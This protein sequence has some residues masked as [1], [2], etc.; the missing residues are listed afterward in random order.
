M[1]DRNGGGAGVSVAEGLRRVD[2]AEALHA[3]LSALAADA[4]RRR[5]WTRTQVRFYL[6]PTWHRN[7]EGY[8]EGEHL[9]A[10]AHLP[11]APQE[12]QALAVPQALALC[13]EHLGSG[14]DERAATDADL[15][16][17]TAGL[18]ELLAGPEPEG[19]APVAHMLRAL[20][21]EMRAADAKQP[22]RFRISQ[23]R[24]VRGDGGRFVY[25][26]IW[27]SE[28]DPYAPGE[29]RLG[30][31]W[32]PARVGEPAPDDA[33]RY[34]IIVEEWLGPAI[35]PTIFRVDPTFLLRV[36]Y[37]RLQA[38]DSMSPDVSVWADRL[39]HPPQRDVA[40]ANLAGA[41]VSDLNARQRDAIGIAMAANRS[42]VWGPPGTGK[43]TTIGALARTQ[44]GLGRRVLILSPY[45]VAVDEAVLSVARGT[46]A[47]PRIL[48]LGRAGTEVR[49][50]GFDLESQLE[51]AAARTGLLDTARGL[52]AAI[53]ARQ[54]GDRVSPPATVRGC[55]DELGGLVVRRGTP[56][57]DPQ[58][59]A[60]VSAVAQ[61]RNAFR[62]PEGALLRGA[63]V[64]ACTMAL[65]FL[66]DE[67]F[68]S[69]F[70]QLI[71]DEA[72]VVRS[73]EAVLAATCAAAPVAFFGDPKQLP[74]IVLTQESAGSRWLG[75]SPFALAGVA[76]PA[77]AAGACVLLDEQHRMAPPIRDI[78]S[79]LFYD[80]KLRDAPNAP[81]AGRVVLV[82]TA[83][84]GARATPKFIRLSQSKENLLHRA[85][86]AE[87][88]R[89][90]GRKNPEA[91]ALVVSP[92]VAQKRAYRRERTT[93]EALR[94]APRFETIHSS[95]GT[96]QDIVVLDLVLAGNGVG[97]R[98]RML[99]ERRN[100]HLPNLLN[101][102]ISRAKHTLVIVGD[103][104]LVQREYADGKLAALV[105]RVR[106]V[107]S[108]VEVERRL[109]GLRTALQ[110]AL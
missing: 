31:R 89:A 104:D 82:N 10:P 3:M 72:S 48:R 70:G 41:P 90:I 59:R 20:R 22:K 103:L 71:V 14:A 49:Q 73:P 18:R 52:L 76:Q 9:C 80:G 98:S 78:V 102:A 61:I 81:R 43:T 67:V 69:P 44:L 99:D 36:V 45:N 40:A 23:G 107:G 60:I 96:E 35:D 19:N 12:L 101:V 63:D 66:K 32:I 7:A 13:T 62:G 2:S 50:A 27:S 105:D 92:F 24:C 34:E 75:R 46:A 51:H 65:A 29:V 25:Q 21:Q 86:V 97:T 88:L 56:H 108:Y 6:P 85:V 53:M 55:L 83:R 26:C 16:P 30:D 38:S 15:P 11:A 68:A 42:Y 4:T 79:S 8:F 84:S 109:A 57:N 1:P 54:P 110:G 39:L 17:C 5:R 28:P 94:H 95:Q 47:P 77:D 37:C 33:L 87:I 64:V 93:A 100:A 91:R 58:S 74:A 106:C